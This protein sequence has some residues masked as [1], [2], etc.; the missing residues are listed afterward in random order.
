MP[1]VVCKVHTATV[2]GH[3]FIQIDGSPMDFGLN[4]ARVVEI[5][6][7]AVYVDCKLGMIEDGKLKMLPPVSDSSVLQAMHE[8]LQSIFDEET[9][10]DNLDEEYG[11]E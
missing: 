2:K 5:D 10:Q 1:S 11:N 4:I 3:R 6:Q 9:E 8:F 7:L